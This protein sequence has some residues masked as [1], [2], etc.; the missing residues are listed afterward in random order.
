MRNKMLYVMVFSTLVGILGGIF[1]PEHM[2]YVRWIDTLFIN[3][4]KLIVIPLAFFAIVSSIISMGSVKRLKSIWLYSLFYVIFSLSIAVIIGLILTNVMKPGIGMSSDIILLHPSS[5][6]LNETPVASISLSYLESLFPPNLINVYD[7]SEFY[8]LPVVLFSVF[9]AIACISVG[10][11]ADP[12]KGL[13]V[14]F[15]NVF[16]KLTIWLMYLTP[17]VM[18]AL[19]GSSIAEGYSKNILM[20]NLTGLLY[21][22]FVLVVGLLCQFMWQYAVVKYLIHRNPREFLRNATGAMFTAFITS[23]SLSTLPM[24]LLAAKEE[25]IRGEVADFVLPSATTI[26]L[27]ATAM[28]EAVATLFFCQIAGIELS[29][30][31]QIGVFFTAILAGIA[32]G[33]IP[34]GGMLTMVMVLRSVNVPTSA[35]ALLLPFD[36][37]LDRFRTMVN[38]WGDLVCAMTVNHFVTKQHYHH[39]SVAHVESDTILIRE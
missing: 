13:I 35:I 18:F 8:I 15:R 17:L 37:I 11:S 30:L 24:T 10:K 4:L 16:N 38:V 28:Y 34:G 19:L 32:S 3:L 39:P 25:K 20:Q 5:K 26:N 31:S 9:F 22:M 27:T 6:I 12:I 21:F 33:G 36:R 29:L 14:A 23:S 2:R 1:F 7:E